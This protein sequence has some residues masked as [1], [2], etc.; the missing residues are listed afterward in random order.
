VII[1][2]IFVLSSQ[3]Y[4]TAHFITTVRTLTR[5]CGLWN[6]LWWGRYLI[7]LWDCHND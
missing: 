5:A 1:L 6:F 7:I 4:A 2:S 3:C